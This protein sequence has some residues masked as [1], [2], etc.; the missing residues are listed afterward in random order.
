M[1]DNARSGNGTVTPRDFNSS[2]RPTWC[3]GC[4]DFGILS[5]LKKAFVDLQLAPHEVMLVSGI[6]CGSKLPDYTNANGFM[7]IHGRPVAV[8]TGIRLANPRLS[9][10]VVNGDGDNYGIGGNHFLHVMRRNVNLTHIVEN[11]QLYALTKGQYSPTSEHGFVTTTSPDGV[12]EYPVLPTDLAFTAGATFIARAFAGQ[13]KQMGDL[14]V[15]ALQHP[16]YALVD[17]L[18]PCVTFNKLNTY[19]W[20]EERA[21][22]VEDEEG[23]DP[24][25]REHAR[26]KVR[27]WGDRIP[28]GLLYVEKRPTYEEQVPGLRRG[29]V[30]GRPLNDLSEELFER[31]KD[32]YV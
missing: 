20:Y 22:Y 10:V 24:A 27:E 2:H 29:P 30:V 31:L 3:P 16:G 14:F 6:G 13:P 32:E 1:P 4:G 7:S 28:L 8:A 23:Y 19:E 9:V 17:V 25:S 21:Y 18:Q 15:R 12:I 5:S 26:Q 11:N